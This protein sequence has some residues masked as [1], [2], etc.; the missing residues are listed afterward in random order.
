MNTN[1]KLLL[2]NTIFLYI[3]TF[4]NYLFGLIILPY[5]TRVL[6]PESFGILG[7]AASF[8]TYFYVV[9][10]F[11]FILFGTKLIAENSVDKNKL[12]C[13]VQS[14]TCAKLILFAVLLLVF[15]IIGFNVTY[16]RTHIGTLMLYLCY[17]CLT[18]LIPDYLYRGLENMKM[19]T[20]RTVLVRFVFTCLIFIFLKHPDQYYLVPLFNIIGT[21]V[22]LC[23]IIYDMHHNIGLRFQKMPFKD[24]TNVLKQ[25]FPFFISRVAATI[26]SAS[27]T[28][29]LGF[30]YPVGNML[31]FYTS[32]DKVRGLV[33][34]AASPIADSFYPYL[35]RTK[36]FRKMFRVT[37][38][39]EV[40]ILL[41]CVVLWVYSE[42]FCVIVFGTEFRSTA[43]ILRHMIPL[44]SIV[45]PSYMFGFPALT[46]IGKAKWANL[47]VEIALINQIIGM[48]VLF[49]LGKI[50]AIS[51]INL[52]FMS[53][54]IS[55]IIRVVVFIS[56]KNNSRVSI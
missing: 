51:L 40:L 17:A 43:D 9:L 19:I 29:I 15:M 8:Y 32:A 24:V 34:Q 49:A 27:N 25:A 50:S 52:T 12:S 44:M 18:C 10:D 53:E 35:L 2:K 56:G 33:S 22:A 28:I 11:G 42:E 39:L 31:G 45:L 7:F 41:V 20:I 55:F 36:D 4:S 1:K 14:I 5:E 37:F 47:S 13:I 23:W 16:L 48:I 26:Y 46:P 38:L 54:C 6:G 30:V 3:L 21:I